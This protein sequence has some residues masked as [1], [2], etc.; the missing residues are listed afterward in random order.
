MKS[1]STNKKMK[2]KIGTIKPT[3]I[4]ENTVARHRAIDR[5]RA[6]SLLQLDEELNTTIGTAIPEMDKINYDRLLGEKYLKWKNRIKGRDL[7]RF[8]MCLETK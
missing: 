1:I 8:S 7:L 6:I 5:K 2:A 4:T 3:S